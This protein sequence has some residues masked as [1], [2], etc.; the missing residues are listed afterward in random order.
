[1][2]Y[3]LGKA[4]WSGDVM[5]DVKDVA[6]LGASALV[7]AA[8]AKIVNDKL[9]SFTGSEYVYPVAVI[10]VGLGTHIMGKSRY[11]VAAP[12]VAAGMVALGIGRLVGALASMQKDADEFAKAYVPFVKLNGLGYTYDS[13][14]M[15]L[16][17]DYG[18]G[19]D[20]YMNG[21]PVQVQSYIAGAPT[22]VQEV[23]GSM[24]SSGMAGLGSSIV[25]GSSPLSASLM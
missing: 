24:P 2:M 14:L 5:E 7:G 11:P 10:G 9:P 21:S 3:G 20:A 8:I 22:Q 13:P 25:G 4:D 15:G 23:Y 1:M 17:F 19:V 12:G 6:K 16:G 18:A